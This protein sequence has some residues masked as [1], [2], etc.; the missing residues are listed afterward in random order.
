[1]IQ[2][3]VTWSCIGIIVAFSVYTVNGFVRDVYTPCR[4][5]IKYSV[6]RF[7]DKFGITEE[8]FLA[9]IKEAEAVWEKEIDTELFVYDPESQ[10]TINLIFDERQEYTFK[11]QEFLDQ[12]EEISEKYNAFEDEYNE[13]K[14]IHGQRQREYTEKLTLFEERV[15]AFNEEVD[16]WNEQGGAPKDEHE[17]LQQEEQVLNNMEVELEEERGELNQV[18]EELNTLAAQGNH[19]ASE[20]N[21]NIRTYKDRFGEKRTFDQGD[22]RGGEIN[23]YHFHSTDDLRLTLAHELGHALGLDH[24]V[25]PTSV[26]HH[27]IGEQ[28]LGL[29]HLTTEDI[30]ELNTACHI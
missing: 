21:E 2:K 5:P 3:V 9:V 8:E 26:M 12:I 13:L 1:M 23:V 4:E 24:V 28:D 22:Y 30:N 15:G 10:F 7:D 6:G 25:N 17:K 20:Y 11:S 19:L 14:E 27:L 29:L 16:Y 18:E